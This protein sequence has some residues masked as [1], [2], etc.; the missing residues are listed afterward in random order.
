MSQIITYFLLLQVNFYRFSISWARIMPD[1][2]NST[3]NQPGVDF[4]N[5]V[6]NGLIAAG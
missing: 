4:Y 6:I 5:N 1:G 2:T 3:I